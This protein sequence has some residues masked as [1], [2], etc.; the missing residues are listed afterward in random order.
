MLESLLRLLGRISL[1]LLLCECL[2][3]TS[4]VLR[5]TV[6]LHDGKYELC[7]MYVFLFRSFGECVYIYIYIFKDVHKKQIC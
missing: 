1:L 6:G 7:E 2:K 4:S 5:Q 3:L